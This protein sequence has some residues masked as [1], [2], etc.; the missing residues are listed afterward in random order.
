MPAPRSPRQRV[1]A[2]CAFQ[3]ADFTATPFSATSITA[4]VV[5]VTA[6]ADALFTP[7]PLAPPAERRRLVYAAPASAAS[8][9]LP[10]PPSSPLHTSDTLP[11]VHAAAAITP[12]R[13]LVHTLSHTPLYT[14][15]HSPPIHTPPS[16]AAIS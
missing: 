13:S 5:A 4:V 11:S 10:P 8:G 16:S 3:P 14:L 12:D 15:D 9:A 7:P 2:C 6:N 1:S